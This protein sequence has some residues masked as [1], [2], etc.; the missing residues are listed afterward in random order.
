MRSRALCATLV[1]PGLA[2]PLGCGPGRLLSGN[3]GQRGNWRQSRSERRTMA[4]Q[5]RRH[6]SD[7][8]DSGR[9]RREGERHGFGRRKRFEQDDD[10][11]RRG[12]GS[13]RD[14]GS[15]NAQKRSQRPTHDERGSHD[16]YRMRDDSRGERR[17]DGGSGDRRPDRGSRRPGRFSD[18]SERKA[19]RD[20]RDIVEVARHS[21][22]AFPNPASRTTSSPQIWSEVPGTSCAPWAVRMPRTLLATW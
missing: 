7:H 13:G 19:S 17:R 9:R 18:H 22:S 15:F 4:Y 2:T 8:G 6:H 10:R 16:E 3:Q 20:R 5:D 14:G 1:L 11:S 12:Y 21:V